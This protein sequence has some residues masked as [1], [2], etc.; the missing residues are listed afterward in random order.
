[1]SRVCYAWL[2]PFPSYCFIPRKHY[3]DLLNRTALRFSEV[4]LLKSCPFLRTFQFKLVT[5]LLTPG[6][7][8]MWKYHKRAFKYYPNRYMEISWTKMFGPYT[9]EI[10]LFKFF[11]FFYL[12]VNL[13]YGCYDMIQNLVSVLCQLKLVKPYNF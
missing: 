9:I 12:W 1:M 2:K 7:S 3:F 6:Y 11:M 4:M 10:L 13:N 8:E 5:L